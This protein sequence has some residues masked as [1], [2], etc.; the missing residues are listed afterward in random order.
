MSNHPKIML[1]IPISGVLNIL[2][3]IIHHIV[4]YITY[5]KYNALIRSEITTLLSDFLLFSMGIGVV[6]IFVGLLTC[7]CYSGIKMN[8]KWAWVILVGVSVLLFIFALAV[9]VVVSITAPIAYV[10][11][12]NSVLIGIPLLI[13]IS[14]F[15]QRKGKTVSYG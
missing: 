2:L 14:E 5:H 12:L 3:G 13:N 15:K 8:E 4:L 11:L 9:I 10:H 6:L 7:Y 1:L